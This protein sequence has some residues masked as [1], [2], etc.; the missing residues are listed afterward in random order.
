MRCEHVSERLEA[1]V[2]GELRPLVASPMQLHLRRCASCAAECR[3]ALAL[4]QRLGRWQEVTAP[5]TLRARVERSIREARFNT[6]PSDLAPPP[7]QRV[8]GTARRA[9]L[10]AV[11][12]GAVAIALVL[13]SATDTPAEEMRQLLDSMAR[14]RTAHA[15]GVF[16]DYRDVGL[17]DVPRPVVVPL[18]YWYQAPDR[19]RRS[20]GPVPE[21]SNLVPGELIAVGTRTA[22]VPSGGGGPWPPGR[23]LDQPDV[24]GM[25][26][27]FDF[28][29]PDGFVR[30][31]VRDRNARLGHRPAALNGRRLLMVTL[32][33]ETPRERQ[34]WEV[35]VDPAADLVLHLERQV[36]VA[37]GEGWLAEFEE[38]L[39]VFEYNQPLS[40]ELFEF[41]PA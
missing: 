31:A 7:A 20:F 19:Y 23:A 15:R 21:G 13:L 24:P 38:R 5:P 4:R 10:L 1:Y 22:F 36:E 18:E 8:S 35:L 25:F 16:V 37:T 33:L 11:P 27:P 3:E 17:P 32:A 30:R 40:K 41:P 12:A 39:E 29:A 34:R 6:L 26:L 14:V 2:D 9:L 28:F